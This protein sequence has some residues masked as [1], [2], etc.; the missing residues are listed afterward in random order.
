M[1][2]ATG[3]LH[4]F[5]FAITVWWN[6]WGRLVTI[7]GM[8]FHCSTIVL[9]T[10]LVLAALLSQSLQYGFW[11]LVVFGLWVYVMANKSRPPRQPR[12]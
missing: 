12:S 4:P 11:A 2:L 7:F 10:M 1:L 9:L 6:F 8:A 3:W 5:R